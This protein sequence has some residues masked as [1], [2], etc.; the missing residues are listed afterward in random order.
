M[1]RY[2][3]I[4]VGGSAMD[5]FIAEPANG[6]TC[7][8]IVLVHHRTGID[9][10]TKDRAERLAEA[11]YVV[12]SPDNFHR[13][14]QDAETSEKT[15]SLKDSELIADVA[16]AVDFLADH[17][18]VED[19]N[20][21]VVGHCMGGRTALLFLGVDQRSTCAAVYYSGSMFA[22]RGEDAPPPFTRL[23]NITCP[24][25]GF[26]G[27]EDHNPT[28]E[29]VD[30]IDAE[31]TKHGVAHVFHRYPGA[32]HAFQDPSHGY[33][34][35]AAKDSWAKTLAFL[36]RELKGESPDAG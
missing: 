27:N 33:H 31:L 22:T 18:R 4:N 13:C 25:V 6:G 15:G 34:E 5:V 2:D 10:F 32:A 28:A 3:Q 35:V 9:D 26:Y 36:A 30:R 24:I 16:A 17:A 1:S 23:G 8:G 12:V 11:G 29:D 14:P 7:P 21:G 20:I 19:G